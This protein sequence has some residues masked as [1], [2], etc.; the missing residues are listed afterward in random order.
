MQQ[1]QDRRSAALTAGLVVLIAVVVATGVPG[2]AGAA[3][4]ATGGDEV[5]ALAAAGSA[6]P[7][8]TGDTVASADSPAE[9]GADVT[10]S[11]A[12]AAGL[13]SPPMTGHEL[14][15][16][17]D[18]PTGSSGAPP[19]GP[20]GALWG[21]AREVVA[22]AAGVLAAGG[23]PPAGDGPDLGGELLQGWQRFGASQQEPE[24]FATDY[25]D[26][27]DDAPGAIDLRWTGFLEDRAGDRLMGA[28]ACTAWSLAD[29][30][31]DG[32]FEWLFAVPGGRSDGPD[33]VGLLFRDDTG[34]L[35]FGV[36]RTPSDDPDTWYVTHRDAAVRSED[37][38]DVFSTLPT[39]ALEGH[40]EFRFAMAVS[41]HAGRADRLPEDH[42][43]L[44]SHPFSC[45]ISFLDRSTVVTTPGGYDQAVAAARARGLRIRAQAPAI[46]VFE[47][48]G[49]DQPAARAALERLPGVVRARPA[50]AL[51]PAAVSPDDPAFPDQWSLPA[52]RAPAG[53]DTRTS[54]GLTLAVVDDGVDATRPDLAGRVLAGRDTVFDV[55]LGTGANSDRGGHGT[56]VAGVAAAQGDNGAELAGLDWGARILPVRVGD[57]AG[58]VTEAAASAGITWAADQGAAVINMSLGTGEPSEALARAVDHAHSRG[59]L[60]V[61]AVGNDPD[62]GPQYPAALPGVVGVGASTRDGSVATYSTRNDSVDLVAPGGDGSGTAG[63]DVLVLAERDTLAPVSGTSFSAPL[64]AAAALLFRAGAGQAGP[65]EVADALSGTAEDGGPAGRDDAYGHGILDV[66]ALLA[67]APEPPP[68]GP[69][70][71]APPGGFDGD[72]RSTERI[73]PG[74]PIRVTI[75]ISRAR[76]AD[77]AAGHAVLARADAFADA[78]AG[79]PLTAGGPLLLTNSHRIPDMVRAELNRA[80]PRDR[81]V[82]LLGGKAAISAA[83]ADTLAAD[84]YRPVRLAGPDRVATSIRIADE[85]VRRFR[86]AP[87]EAVVARAGASGP[88]PTAAWAD[89]LTGG[90]WAAHQRVPLLLTPTGAL[91]DRVAGWLSRRQVDRTVLLGG[92]AALSRRVAAAAPRPHRVAGEDR[93]HTAVRIS[94]D[95]WRVGAF[96]PRRY[97][98]ADGRR[99][100]GWAF[101]LPA[102][103]L[104]ADFAAP[105]LLTAPDR[106]PEA[107]LTEVVGCDDHLVDLLL[108]GGTGV[109][110]ADQQATLNTQDNTNCG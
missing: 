17:A 107:T 100:D 27:C 31:A 22:G 73:F 21:D 83:V 28:G 93:A 56:Q 84:G 75:S 108:V 43:D 41:D 65:A 34:E 94:R 89:S 19:T 45:R 95:L 1:G 58:C 82:Y 53:W 55:A 101:G 109:I 13:T 98:I 40:S 59:A 6:A 52:V 103:G 23:G 37:G 44:L 2:A 92:A 64:V 86:E 110:T 79:T 99:A 48:R 42:E 24:F 60:V 36:L 50:G 26:V 25:V 63:G 90:G 78:L 77:G 29:L 85:V 70:G 97:V 7:G 10:R 81:T 54:S 11:R 87:R 102:A 62:A 38:F 72:A 66:E 20:V 35:V 106:V 71:T 46:G 49:G 9:A 8:P 5:A 69:A 91:D 4:P 18:P 61:A 96:G 47:I 51:T 12:D 88:D 39:T 32:A 15:P 14:F 80:L 30:G 104:A 105:L 68:E 16:A 57:A 33:Y 67:A 3:G 76:F 74:E